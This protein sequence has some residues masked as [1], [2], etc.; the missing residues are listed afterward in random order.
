MSYTIKQLAH[1]AKISV[2]TLHHYDNIGLLKPM[3]KKGNQ[4]R[5]YEESDLLK[6]QQVL[7]FRELEFSLP[8]IKKILSSPAFDMHASLRDQRKLIELKKKRISGILPKAAH[9]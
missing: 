4:Y 9:F 3:R 7:F 2:R 1:I 5:F 8:E 6:L